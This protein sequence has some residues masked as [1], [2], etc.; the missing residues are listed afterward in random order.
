MQL[1]SKANFSYMLAG[2]ALFLLL[3]PVAE[4]FLGNADG[5]VLM[6]AYTS[7]LIVC[8]WTLHDSKFLFYLG[9]GLAAICI[10]M[11]LINVI[12]ASIDLSAYLML[13][14][15]I[16][17]CMSIWTACRYVFSPGSIT[18]NKLMGGVCLYLLLGLTWNIF[19]VFAFEADPTSFTGISELTISNENVYWDM[20]YFSFVTL[21]TLGYGDIQPVGA[22]AKV[23]AYSEAIVGEIYIAVLIGALVGSYISE[24]DAKRK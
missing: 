17:Q 23:L 7:M 10:G 2:I 20:T 19:Y 13:A 6:I 8:I 12:S 15:L 18:M 16:F 11:T 14:L 4:N 21:T 22:I 24:R 5:A 9:M 3:G 1:R